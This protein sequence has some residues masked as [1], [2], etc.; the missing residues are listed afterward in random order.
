[1]NA[2]RRPAKPEQKGAGLPEIRLDGAAWPGLLESP[3]KAALEKVLPA[4]IRACRWYGGKARAIKKLGISGLINIGC[5][6]MPLALLEILY[7]HGAPQTYLLPLAWK[8]D[9]RGAGILKF[10][11]AALIAKLELSGRRGFLYD[12]AYDKEFHAAFLALLSGTR[13]PKNCSPGLAVEQNKPLLKAALRKNPAAPGSRLLSGEQSNTSIVYGRFFFS[14]LFRRLEKGI[15]PDVEIGARLTKSRLFSG[16]PPFLASAS[17]YRK[18]KFYGV[19]G[20]LQGYIPSRGDSWTYALEQVSAY[21]K[22]VLSSASRAGPAPVAPDP[23]APGPDSA[24]RPPGR[25]I[26]EDCLRLMS[27]LGRRTA[28]MHLALYS[29]GSDP[30]F[31]PETFGPASR[32][33]AR[34]SMA[35]LG[36]ASLRLLSRKLKDLPRPLRPGA[37]LL[38]SSRPAVLSAFGAV[39]EKG[40]ALK[41]IR[42]HGDFHLGQVLFT[43]RDFVIIDFE[44][45]P[46]KPI[47][48]RRL[49]HSAL[50]DVAGMLRSFHYAAWAPFCLR[51]DLPA[52]DRRALG[53]WAELWYSAVSASFLKAYF[54]TCGKAAFLPGD[55][56]QSAALLRAFLM[57]KAAY[58]LS[59]ELNNRPGWVAIPLKG[60]LQ[61]LGRAGEPGCAAVPREKR[62]GN[63][64]RS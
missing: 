53:P 27:L 16:M 48:E 9:S 41:K 10:A 54:R 7:S 57:E 11:P 8:E 2:S 60:L 44:G 50:R 37:S 3:E 38:L 25:L 26:G 56:A 33:S 39:T 18:G 40:G 61:L 46:A 63:V 17:L 43:G 29:A 5:G 62:G 49:K 59:Y 4:Y 14:K 21:Y 15:N 23:L 64:G 13:L 58:E 55:L 31:L 1:M 45:E 6:S 35:E 32:R 42:V 20:L 22:R 24:A 52:G 28:E 19:L 12:A 47:S 34:R 30:A 36:S 51:A